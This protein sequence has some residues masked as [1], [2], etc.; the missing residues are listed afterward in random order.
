M[1]I[2]FPHL[3]NYN[4]ALE[5]LLRIMLP[6]EKI[7]IAPPNSKKTIE[8]G[9]KHSPDF[10]CVPF[11]Y[12]LGNMIEALEAGA[13]VLCVIG[14]GCRYGYYGELQEQILRD[15]G[16]KFTFFNPYGTDGFSLKYAYGAF[17]KLGS[18]AGFLK[19]VYAAAL[20]ARKMMI[21]DRVDVFIRENIGFETERGSFESL[22]KAFYAE[23]RGALSFVK[24]R[25]AANK[26]NRLFRRLPVSKPDAP[27]NVGLIGELYTVMEPFANYE[28][29]KELARYNIRVSRF[30]DVT[31][32]LLKNKKRK[33][34]RN[35]RQS[36]GY[37]KYYL[38]ADATHSVAKCRALADKGCDGVIHVKPFGCTPEINAMPIL[39]NIGREHKLPVLFFSFDEQTSETGV[40]TRLEAFYDMISM[41]RE[42]RE[43]T[44]GNREQG[45]I[46]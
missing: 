26:Y 13:D 28:M 14:G 24:M 41:K 6:D 22:K 46:K 31:Y 4:V 25:K 38:G 9:A 20:T 33:E 11:K 23:L 16:Y 10:V 43:Q 17:K 3:A 40:K 12:N 21:M 19:F 8:L 5:G 39:M 1:T 36:K 29:E 34:R 18:P 30:T 2:S 42:N 7:L 27:L 35:V 45:R 44:A 32:L 37:V 15:L